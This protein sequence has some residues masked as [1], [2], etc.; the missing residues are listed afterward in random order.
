MFASGNGAS[1]KHIYF[2]QMVNP[3]KDSDRNHIRDDMIMYVNPTEQDPSS[4][5]RGK[6]TA[7]IA[8]NL[9]GGVFGPSMAIDVKDG[10]GCLAKGLHWGNVNSMF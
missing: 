10:P 1:A 3:S 9:G 4:P 2:A 7:V 5:D 8:V 6:Q